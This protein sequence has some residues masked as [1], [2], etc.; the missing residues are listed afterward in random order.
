ML[1]NIVE[2]MAI[3]AGTIVPTVFVLPYEPR[4]N[5]FCA[6]FTP[7]TSVVAVSKGALDSLSRDELQGVVAHEFS[8]LLNG[9]CQ[10][11]LRLVGI[12]NG[13]LCIAIIG[14]LLL[15]GSYQGKRVNINT[16]SKRKG[17]DAA[18]AGIGI[19]LI[20]IGY[21]GVLFGKIIKSAVSRQR[22]FLADASAVQFTRNPRGILSALNKIQDVGSSINHP[23]AEEA[24][25]MFF[26]A[27]VTNFFGGLFATHPPLPQRIKRLAST[28]AVQAI[29]RELK[30][31]N[32]LPGPTIE[33]N[34][35]AQVDDLSPLAQRM[36]KNLS[37]HSSSSKIDVAGEEKINPVLPIIS[38][39]M[40]LGSIGRFERASVEVSNLMMQAIPFVVKEAIHSP[41]KVC[42]NMAALLA[43][44]S[45][46][47]S[48]WFVQNVI[49]SDD[50][51]ISKSIEVKDR[52]AIHKALQA[53]PE[54][55]YL[56]VFQI[57]R[58]ALMTCSP[59]KLGALD[60]TL[61]NIIESDSEIS[62]LEQCFYFALKDIITSKNVDSSTRVGKQEL[63]TSFYTVLSFFANA[64]YGDEDTR[65]RAY[66]EAFKAFG[67]KEEKIPPILSTRR[68]TSQ[69]LFQSLQN[70][71]SSASPTLKRNLIQ[72]LLTAISIDNEFDTDEITVFRLVGMIIEVPVG[73]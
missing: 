19:A 17:N 14:R 73:I 24:S 31:E 48:D 69:A 37:R 18:L 59:E 41:I 64:C 8:H 57:A 5:A 4:I 38:G 30:I 44:H 10:L 28:P 11:N 46:Q 16:S 15:R 33:E 36:V 50:A 72:A 70:L 12:L 63:S 65:M 9:D 53:L 68:C 43:C 1:V 51:L 67:T 27:G 26:A 71:K 32:A 22:E 6:G 54:G 55:F 13:L 49:N 23:G 56:Q 20:I 42:Y 39:S 29:L 3:A 61:Q 62:L 7:S 52:I 34:I 45:E 2:E 21:V 47:G 60:T 58:P 66:L 40:L 25:H 35:A